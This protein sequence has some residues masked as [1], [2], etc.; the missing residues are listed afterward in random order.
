MYTI[1]TLKKATTNKCPNANEPYRGII[2]KKL[3]T[4]SVHIWDK[5]V[6]LVTFHH[7]RLHGYI[8]MKKNMI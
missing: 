5:R 1:K 8:A 2:V 6:F 7:E 3:T 4:T